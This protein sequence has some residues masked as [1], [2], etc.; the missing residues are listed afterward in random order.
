MNN[1]INKPTNFRNFNLTNGLEL[2]DAKK[3]HFF[4]QL[5]NIISF[6]TDIAIFVRSFILKSLDYV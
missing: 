5:P 3:E 2:Y 1:K 6:F 4:I